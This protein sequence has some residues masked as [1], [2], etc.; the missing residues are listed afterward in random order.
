MDLHLGGD[1]DALRRLVEQQHVHLRARAIWPGSP[2]ADCR[3]TASRPAAPAGAGGYR[4]APSGRAR[5]RSPA[6]RSIQNAAVVALEA[7][8]QNIVAHRQVHHQAE[9]AFARHEADIGRDRVGGLR[10]PSRCGH[11]RGGFAHARRQRRTAGARSGRCRCRA[12]RRGRWSRLRAP[13]C[14]RGVRAVS[15]I[16]VL[17]RAPRALRRCS[18]AILPVMSATRS[19]MVK[20]PRGAHRD[21]LPSRS[22]VQRSARSPISSS[23]CEI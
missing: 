23:R 11:R 3:R 18:C 16:S 15:S 7:R 12:G 10:Q 19:A 1:V 13:T 6:A 22:T 4:E 17:R 5:S 2:S 21:Q 8:Q 14:G 20:L 9:R